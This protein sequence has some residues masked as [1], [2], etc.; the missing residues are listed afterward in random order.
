MPRRQSVNQIGP[1]LG[2]IGLLISGGLDSSIL[3]K[4]LLDLGKW[5]QPFYIRSGLRWQAAEQRALEHYLD[6]V[7]S[8]CLNPLVV[9][10]L[11]LRDVYGAHWSITGRNIPRAGTPDEAVF[12]P[13]RNA[14][15]AIKAALWCQLHGIDELAIATLRSNP[16]DDASASFLEQLGKALSGTRVR[17]IR[18]VRPFG[19]LDKRQV[20]ELGRAFPLHLTFSCIAPRKMSHCGRC[21]KCA[22]RRAAFR[23]I[24]GNDPT[25]YGVPRRPPIYGHQRNSKLLTE[26][27]TMTC[28]FKA[29]DHVEWNSEAGHIRGTIK[30]KITSEIKFKGYTVRASKK[31]PQYLIKSDKT[32]HLAMHKGSALK[33]LKKG[34][35]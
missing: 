11:P 27:Q 22:E 12:L 9:L 28:E 31:V 29:G 15:L 24:G 8:R 10:D 34:T 21:N 7:A 4:Y 26:G 16:F 5:V 30:K 18:L 1:Q 19:E 33:K 14:L 32:D 6:A 25:D 2:V 20:M 17:P 35:R 13:G 3:L 23:L